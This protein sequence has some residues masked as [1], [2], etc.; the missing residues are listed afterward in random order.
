MKRLPKWAYRPN[1]NERIYRGAYVTESG[2]VGL[3]HNGKYELL[4]STNKVNLITSMVELSSR[5]K[6][7]IG[8]ANDLAAVAIQGV[9]E[10]E[11]QEFEAKQVEINAA[12][13][14]LRRVEMLLANWEAMYPDGIPLPPIVPEARNDEEVDVLTDEEDDNELDTDEPAVLE[15]EDGEVDDSE[16]EK[17]VKDE[18]K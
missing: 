5:L 7:Q 13:A 2:W 10:M 14:N 16:D 15:D 8:I 18:D 3:R 17:E 4:V 12:L 6:I 1:V 9:E 11:D